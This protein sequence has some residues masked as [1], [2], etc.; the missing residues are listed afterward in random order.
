M[1]ETKKVGSII[2]YQFNN[3]VI[4]VEIIAIR[5][6]V[7]KEYLIKPIHGTGED[8]ISSFERKTNYYKRTSDKKINYKL[9]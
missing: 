1:A 8:W 3:I 5:R 4:D 7:K 2:K 6:R 9:K